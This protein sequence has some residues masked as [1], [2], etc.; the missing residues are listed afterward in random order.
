[1]HLRT[2]AIL[3]AGAAL[4]APLAH[5]EAPGFRHFVTTSGARLMDGERELR[6]ISMNIPNLHYVE[7][8]M[9][10]AQPMAYRL[11]DAFEIRDALLS[12]RQ[13]GG[14]VV[15]TY[16][17]PVR[18]GAHS[19][20]VPTYVLGPGEFDEA[21]FRT[22]DLV[23]A[24]ANEIGIR[25]IIPFVNNSKWMGGRPDY[26][27]FRGKTEDDFWTDRQLI[28]DFK[29]T[30]AFVL[31]RTNT[32]TGV[33]YREDKAILCWET[34]N[35]LMGPQAWTHEIAAYIKS[36]DPNHLVMDGFNAQGA[37]Y[38]RE[39]SVVDSSID[40]INSHHYETDPDEMLADIRANL[41]IVAGRKPY[42]IGEF[43]F[44]ST[45]AIARILDTIVASRIAGALV[46]SLRSHR[47]EGGFYWHSEPFGGGVYK[48]YHWPGFA[49]GEPYDER[50]LL[51]LMRDRAY[52]IRGEPAPPVEAATTALLLPID[53]PAHI[54]WQGS[55][56]AASYAV[57]R[58][59]AANGPWT[60]LAEGIDDA[61]T[62]YRPLFVDT[63]APVGTTVF[64]RVRARNSAGLSAFSN[65]VGPVRVAART[66]VDPMR[67]LSVVYHGQGPLALSGG[68]DR[69]FKETTRRVKGEAGAELTYYV[70]GTIQG[71]QVDVFAAEEGDPLS[72]LTSVDGRIYTP[73]APERR[74]FFA[75]QEDYGYWAPIRY[76]AS[77]PGEARY[78]RLVFREAAEV[79]RVEIAYR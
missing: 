72:L 40:I 6:F 36:L 33:P 31:G 3:S 59:S 35:E 51:A 38:V 4:L 49:S 24:Q 17:L 45:P 66:L 55:V 60:T 25:L 21:A 16:S 2:L 41:A 64:Y 75:G 42:V 62:Q 28:E 78:L 79:A 39:E 27:A 68:D 63:S 65:V 74:S 73:V 11:P 57:E 43:G 10:F 50:G 23:L 61:D 29:R 1:M 8:E 5:A 48:A 12:V 19:P 47:R 56:G 70:P 53:D 69:R 67:N 7:D 76:T 14:S 9:D 30:V 32:I 58:A 26:A 71:F 13:M 77:A 44:V 52:A 54:S 15:R 46:W 37:R 18:R 20:D 34:G 22:L